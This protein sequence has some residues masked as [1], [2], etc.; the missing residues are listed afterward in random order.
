MKYS[1]A[2]YANALKLVLAKIEANGLELVLKN[3]QAVLVK[4]GDQALGDKIVS[5]LEGIFTKENG[6]RIVSIETARVLPIEELELLKKHFK[7]KDLI[8]FKLNP[9][10]V[11]GVR[12]TV[13][14]DRE[15]DHS[16]VKKL[17]Q[18]FVV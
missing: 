6:G 3:F 1:P 9:S 11:A 5:E 17:R 2:T 7:E 8:R 16:L 14:G 12:V 4:N 13:G 10:L 18:V 15:L